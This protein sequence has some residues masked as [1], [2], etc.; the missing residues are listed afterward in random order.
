MKGARIATNLLGRTVRPSL[1]TPHAWPWHWDFRVRGDE[2]L[3]MEDP[4]RDLV[5]DG[6][7]RRTISEERATIVAVYLDKDGEVKATLESAGSY[8]RPGCSAGR[9][10]DC[11]MAHVLLIPVS[12]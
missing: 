12:T 10:G 6:L 11:Y 3:K 8:E 7:Y 1:A 5:G 4:R 9:V 2:R